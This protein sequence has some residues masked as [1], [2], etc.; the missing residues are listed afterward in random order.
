[1][2]WLIQAFPFRVEIGLAL[3]VWNVPHSL[4]HLFAHFVHEWNFQHSTRFFLSLSL[5]L[6]RCCCSNSID[7]RNI[8]LMENRGTHTHTHMYAKGAVLKIAFYTFFSCT[9]KKTNSNIP[10]ICTDNRITL[11]VYKRFHA[12]N[13]TSAIL[14]YYMI[15]WREKMRQHSRQKMSISRKKNEYSV[16]KK[17]AA[18]ERFFCCCS[19]FRSE[20]IFIALTFCIEIYI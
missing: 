20:N 4:F 14:C 5:P 9:V 15:N 1:M 18:S 16:A 11:C 12:Q 6:F 2:F 10:C 3:F 7:M 19:V 17:R 13:Y 8:L